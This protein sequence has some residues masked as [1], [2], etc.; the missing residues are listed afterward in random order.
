MESTPLTA[1][2]AR[3]PRIWN[4]MVIFLHQNVAQAETLFEKASVIRGT[5]SQCAQNAPRSTYSLY[6]YSYRAF[7]NIALQL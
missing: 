5:Q 4:A 1:N 2:R 6:Y 7:L 3:T